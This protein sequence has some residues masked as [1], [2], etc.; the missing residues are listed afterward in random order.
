MTGP[1]VSHTHPA[2]DPPKLRTLHF[3]PGEVV[4]LM[5]PKA[6]FKE[7]RDDGP[8]SQDTQTA[9]I[10]KYGHR[11]GENPIGERPRV[12]LPNGKV[13]QTM[14]LPSRARIANA[15]AN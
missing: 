9:L 10:Q 8:V 1:T 14:K 7:A 4:L 12:D 15:K 3:V 11:W 13:L 2:T 6:G 5:K